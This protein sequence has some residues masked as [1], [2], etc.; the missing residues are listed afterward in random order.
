[1]ASASTLTA[2]AT[3]RLRVLGCALVS[4]QCGG[5]SPPSSPVSHAALVPVILFVLVH[6]RADELPGAIADSDPEFHVLLSVHRARVNRVRA[7]CGVYSANIVA[8]HRREG[9]L[10]AYPLGHSGTS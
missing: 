1:V 5:R 8:V 2:A 7:G 3:E 6:V 9:H 4:C 10:Q